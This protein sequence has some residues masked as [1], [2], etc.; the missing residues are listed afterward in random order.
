MQRTPP[1]RGRG[2]DGSR[3]RP[4]SRAFSP[5]SPAALRNSTFAS[6]RRC[7]TRRPVP[8][9]RRPWARFP[10]P[11]GLE[12]D[13]SGLRKDS[14][15]RQ[16]ES[17]PPEGAATLRLR[18]ARLPGPAAQSPSRGRRPAAQESALTLALHWLHSP[19]GTCEVD[20]GRGAE[21]PA[22]TCKQAQDSHV[23]PPLD[24]L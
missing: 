6:R 16:A 2:R 21:E 17:S 18:P 8:C 7:R 19:A 11:G 20:T 3:N 10:L 24:L 15:G 22:E 14:G 1:C 4:L 12:R 5:W 13:A 23:R 9:N